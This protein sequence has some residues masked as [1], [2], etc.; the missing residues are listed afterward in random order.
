[1]QRGAGH[2]VSLSNAAR[3]YHLK[4]LAFAADCLERARA[5]ASGV[6]DPAL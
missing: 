3:V 4:A 2:N 5:G 6:S 1:V